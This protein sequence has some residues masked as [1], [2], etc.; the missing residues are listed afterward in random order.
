[1]QTRNGNVRQKNYN[2]FYIALLVLSMI[3]LAFSTSLFYFVLNRNVIAKGVFAN[4]V[5]LSGLTK[6]QAISLLEKSLNVPDNIELNLRYGEK[7]YKMVSSDF[8][9]K[10]DYEKIAD[11]AYKIGREGNLLERIRAIYYVGRYGKY[12]R[13]YPGWDSSKINQ[14]IKIASKDIDRKPV[15]AKIHVVDGSIQ[16]TDNIEGLKVDEGKTFENIKSALNKLLKGNG[17][18]ADVL[19]AVDKVDAKVK[20]STLEMIKNKVATYSTVFNTA[21]VN[22]SENLAVAARAVN[23]TLLM[24]G[25]KFSLNKTLGPR[26][27]ENGYKEA[28]VIVGNKLVPDIG[29]GV[30]QV[31]TTLYNAVLRADIKI[32]E[33]YHHTFP[34]GYVPA[35]QDATIS[36]DLLDLKFENSSQYP[37]YIEANINGNHFTVNLYGY[38]K[39]PSKRIEIYSEVV[40]KYEPK[41]TYIDDPTLPEGEEIVDTAQHTGY[42]VNTYRLIYVNN[43][44]VKKEFLYTDVYKPVDGI[45]KK[46]IKKTDSQKT[47]KADIQ[48]ENNKI[49]ITNNSDMVNVNMNG[50]PQNIK[51][52][53]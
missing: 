29:G 4:G 1:M 24:P 45:I 8:G 10:Y 14:F 16:I 40:E 22:R 6:Q 39:D 25:E 19:I 53:N 41:I 52:T 33:R 48:K 18:T 5:N 11:D 2:Y 17:N 26:I 50:Q 28:P 3:L 20:K 21:D 12:L 27:I 30:C 42:K 37:L 46:G 15:D 47:Q 44:L 36:G 31:A 9:L 43:A 35:G 34:V 23:G 38:T 7:Q 32:D 51:P 49:N 13:Y